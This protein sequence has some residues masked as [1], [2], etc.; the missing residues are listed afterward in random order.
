MP[1]L[2]PSR[3][4]P[5]VVI[6][7]DGWGIS[8]L[9]EGNAIAQADTPMMD[10]YIREYPSAAL[11]ASGPEVGLPWG[12]VGNS[13]TGHRSIGAGKVMYQVLPKIDK[14]IQDGTFFENKVLIDAIDHAKKNNSNLHLMG[15][16]SDGGVHSHIRHL[17]A[18]LELCKKEQFQERVY[19]HLFTD[20]RDTPKQRA[21]IY[22]KQ[23]EEAMGK[24]AT[25]TIATVMGRL[26]A[27]DRNQNWDRT[28]KAYNTLIGTSRGETAAFAKNAIA[29]F[30]QQGIFDEQM[31]PITLTR[32]GEAITSIQDNDAI[33]FFNFRPD[34]ARQITQAFMQPDAVGFSAKPLQN[35]YFAT[36]AKYD[37]TIPAPYAFVEDVSPLPL[38]KA[39]SDAGLTQLHIAETEKYAHVTY[40]LNVGNEQP[41][42]QQEDVL[43]K[44][45]NVTD[46]SQEPL[47][48]AKEITD[49]VIEDLTA[50]P[51]DVYFINLANADMVGHTG[52][53]EAAVQACTFID[54]CIARLHERV[55]ALGGAIVVTA[56][57]GN[58]EEMINPTTKAVETDHTTNPVVI[59]VVSEHVR[60]SH[61]KTEQEITAILTTPIG[62]LSDVA[63]TILDI[64]AVEKPQIMTG[65]SLLSSLR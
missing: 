63:P 54:T 55:F 28:E 39:I 22:I 7:L 1:S 46:F 61:P 10:M 2:F 26:Y 8:L 16:V 15:M 43:I 44:S 48:R 52:N 49:R 9:S 37:D 29:R 42:P 65:V 24:F 41:Y 13:E 50:S 34:R 62:V 57:H 4:K 33:I 58:A 23:L 6:I 35:I 60:R 11:S 5:L 45:S 59:H 17:I 18:L 32:G 25:G 14:A 3:P 21:P 31:P 38:A 19:I 30:Y 36:M 12:E 51:R 56:D 64:L 27:M 47:M 53:F 20:G 40:Y